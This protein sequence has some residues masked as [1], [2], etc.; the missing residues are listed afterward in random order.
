M[1]KMK[2]TRARPQGAPT[3]E[4][5]FDSSAQRCIAMRYGYLEK[6]IRLETVS[7]TEALVVMNVYGKMTEEDTESFIGVVECKTR[8]E[9]MRIQE[10][11]E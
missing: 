2:F 6:S 7:T 1:A 5:E 9:M 8:A 4:V 10:Y 11:Y 3:D